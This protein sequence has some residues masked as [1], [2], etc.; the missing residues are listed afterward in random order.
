[1]VPQSFE[2]G[3]EV[4]WSTPQGKTRGTVH[5]MFSSRTE[6]GGQKIVASKED[7]A[8]LSRASICEMSSSRRKIHRGPH[9]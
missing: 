7:P 3:D 6:V 8:T 2:Q 5:K 4:E 9:G 1:M